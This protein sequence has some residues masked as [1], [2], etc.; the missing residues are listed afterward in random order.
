MGGGQKFSHRQCGSQLC[1]INEWLKLA[2]MESLSAAEWHQSVLFP[3][4]RGCLPGLDVHGEDCGSWLIPLLLARSGRLNWQNTGNGWT[5]VLSPCHFPSQGHM[6][7]YP[8]SKRVVS[9]IAG[10]PTA[11]WLSAKKI[12]NFWIDLG[13][14]SLFGL[15]GEPTGVCW[16]STAKFWHYRCLL[17]NRRGVL[18]TLKLFP[19]V[20][21]TVIDIWT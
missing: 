2:C 16:P 13:L 9:T 8:P 18:I 6:P 17:T 4:G 21:W 10:S 3:D 19:G 15:R 11:L 7:I 14:E 20:E 12:L 5:Q 1:R